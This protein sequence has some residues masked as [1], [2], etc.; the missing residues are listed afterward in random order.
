MPVQHLAELS[1]ASGGQLT[2]L[3]SSCVGAGF[4]NFPGRVPH[5][6]EGESTPDGEILME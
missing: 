3:E 1:E 4:A 5:R 2:V 6:E